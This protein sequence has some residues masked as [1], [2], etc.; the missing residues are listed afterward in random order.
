[1]LAL[2]LLPTGA[3]AVAG[4]VEWNQ[5]A[6]TGPTPS[7]QPYL[8]YDSARN[9]T[10]LFGGAPT[11]GSAYY[12][13]TWEYDGTNWSKV[14]TA[15]PSGRALGQMVYDSARG[16]SV[17]FGGATANSYLGETWEWNGSAWTQRVTSNAPA[18]RLWF[19]MTYDSARQRTVLF[20]GSAS[21]NFSLADTW[22]YDGNNWTQVATVHT[23]PGRYGEG[24]AFDSARNRVVMFGGHNANRL[25]DTWEY[26]GTD[27]TQVTTTTSPAPRFWHSMG[28]DPS[29]QRTVIF[30]G[31]YLL[32]NTLGPNNE[33]WEYDGSNW[34]QLLTTIKPSPRIEAPMAYDSVLGGLMIFGGSDESGRPDVALG[35]TWMLGAA[36][37]TAPAAALS[38]ASIAF[39]QQPVLTTAARPVTL[40][41]TG[42]APLSI[43]SIGGSGDFGATDGCPR[44]PATL[45]AGDSC[46]IT[47]SFSPTTGNGSVTTGSLTVIDDAGTGTQSIPLSGSGFWGFLSVSPSALDFGSNQ[48][49]PSGGTA[50][51]IVTITAPAQTT[52]I[53]GVEAIG[54]FVAANLDCPLNTPISQGASCRIMVGFTPSTPGSY[55]GQLVIHD[56]EPGFQRVVALSG[57]ATPV[58]PP[59]VSI[60]LQLSLPG[61]VAHA[62]NVL[63]LT[64]AGSGQ[65]TFTLAGKQLGGPIELTAGYAAISINLDDSVIP[66]GAGVYPLIVS[67][68]STDPNLSDASVTQL[69]TVQPETVS[70][71]WSGTSL[72]TAGQIAN[73]SVSV[74]PLFGDSEFVDFNTHPVW[75][76]FEVTDGSGSTLTYFAI[77]QDIITPDGYY[78]QGVASVSGPALV[79]G[80]YQVRVRLVDAVQSSN[81]NPFAGS[82]DLRTALAAHP[83]RGGWL[84]GVG[85]QSS[86]LA[87]DF[88]VGKAPAGSVVWVFPTQVVGVDGQWHDAYRV[89]QSTSVQ[90]LS[91]HK[92]TAVVSG[93]ISGAIVDASTAQDYPGFDVATTFTLTTDPSGSVQLVTGNGDFFWD[94]LSPI[95]VINHL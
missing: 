7:V 51:A 31:D 35:D 5:S 45:A 22:E 53:T 30:G 63:A 37:M 38:V 15:G 62:L 70:L 52:V 82:E 86:S 25:N 27:W 1:M 85:Q 93:Q 55:A 46:T 89:Y 36:L 18:P 78:G 50:A 20:G 84:A 24:L 2:G 19:G 16:V 75:A 81:P 76:R 57:V 92:G 71:M 61:T 83:A 42:N 79:A 23:P 65:A 88:T 14:A 21:G 56:S 34:S 66:A 43:T 47:V 49:N 28:Y 80:A 9:R 67:V 44:S 13:D 48:I 87:F 6:A 72:G 59:P 73:L 64:D 91:N 54:T 41:N 69:V 74:A 10:V 32:P 95:G 33:T 90:S 11:S 77:V 26:N 4:P 12:S 68:H 60:R 8:S 29:R 3:S 58:P 94:K 40:V 39:P 17:L